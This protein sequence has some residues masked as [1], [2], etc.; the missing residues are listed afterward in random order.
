MVQ[1]CDL[2]SEG[3]VHHKIKQRPKHQRLDDAHRYARK[4][5]GCNVCGRGEKLSASLLEEYL[6]IIYVNVMILE[7]K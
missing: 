2:Q 1:K 3:I 7:V 6:G 4:R 5:H